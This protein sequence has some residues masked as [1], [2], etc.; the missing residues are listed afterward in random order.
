MADCSQSLG[1]GRERKKRARTELSTCKVLR[2]TR[3]K[4]GHFGDAKRRYMNASE[5]RE[6]EL[7]R[8]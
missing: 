3:H 7:E 4:T 2:P 8:L 5:K 6:A 1:C